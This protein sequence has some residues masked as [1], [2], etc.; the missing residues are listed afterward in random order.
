MLGIE[1][2]CSCGLRQGSK[3]KKDRANKEDE[4]EGPGDTIDH[5]MFRS[6]AGQPKAPEYHTRAMR[7]YRKRVKT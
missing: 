6:L 2:E 5:G 4:K 3:R 7:Y 1:F